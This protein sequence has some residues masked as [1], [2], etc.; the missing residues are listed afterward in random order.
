M[1]TSGVVG[2]KLWRFAQALHRDCDG[3]DII[4]YALIAG[5]VATAVVT[6]VPEISGSID[7]IMAKVNSL[8]IESA[9]S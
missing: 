1:T 4:E 3:Q 9:S 8:M 7:T 5:F 2:R 6:M